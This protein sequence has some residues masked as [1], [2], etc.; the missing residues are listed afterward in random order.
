MVLLLEGS[1][2]ASR[3]ARVALL[4]NEDG[5]A[6]ATVTAPGDGEEDVVGEYDL[7]EAGSMSIAQE[8]P[9]SAKALKQQML[10]AA[11]E[12]LVSG[13]SVAD[14]TAQ[15]MQEYGLTRNK[16]YSVVLQVKKGMGLLQ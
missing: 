3:A 5:T 10:T 2:T 9:A 14:V 15:L 11:R 1:T 7:P 12:G 16:V 13:M 4:C 8:P 6:L